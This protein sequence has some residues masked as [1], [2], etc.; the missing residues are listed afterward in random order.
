[1]IA[2]LKSLKFLDDRPVFDEDRRF[3]EAFFAGGEE[4]EEK[5]KFKFK[6]EEEAKHIRNHLMFK[7]LLY[8]NRLVSN[9][10]NWA[11]PVIES[12]PITS[13][14]RFSEYKFA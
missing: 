1:M 7:E 12:N 9:G 6:K 11:P 8:S 10:P 14:Q 4:E 3:A 13:Y 2:K 5:E